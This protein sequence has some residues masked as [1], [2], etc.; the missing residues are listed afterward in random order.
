MKC[1]KLISGIVAIMLVAVLAFGSTAAAFGAQTDNGADLALASQNV[2][3]LTATTDSSASSRADSLDDINEA[4]SVIKVILG[5]FSSS[6]KLTWDSFKTGVSR[7]FYMSVDKLIDSLVVGL[8]KVFPLMSRPDEADYKFTNSNVGSKSFNDK[9]ADGA[10]WNVGYSS[11]TLLTG[12]ELDGN[13][14][15]GGS[16]S[17]PNP[18][19]PTEIL[20]DLRVRVFAMSDGTGNG[21]VVYAV[22][23]AYGLA[24]KDVREIRSRIAGFIKNKN[25]VSVN[26]STLHQHSAID[27]LGLNGDLNKVLFENTFKNA[28]G[29]DPSTLHNGQNKEYM[30]HLYK[31][32][33]DSIIAA[34]NNMEPG[35]MYFSQTDVHEYI[36]DKRDPQTFDPNLNRLCF[37]P[38]NRESKPTWIVNAAIHCVGLGAGTTNIS[39]DYPYFI[40]KQVNAAGANYVQIQGAE[41]AITS[42]TAPVAVEGNTRYQNVEAYGNKL[43][44][45]LVAADKGSRV[46]PILNIAHRDVFV[47][48]DNHALEFIASTG[49]LANEAVKAKDG[50]MRIPTEIGYMEIGTNLAFALI[51]GELAPEIAFGGGTEAKDS[52]TGEDWEYPSM[53]DIVGSR[54]LMVL[55]LTND[56]IGYIIADNNYHSILTENEEL[57]TVSKHEGSRIL[58]E[59]KS[60][61]E[62]VR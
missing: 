34:V 55:G 50:S 60:L 56:Q 41:L 54:K 15:V 26:I 6:D 45:I 9:A 5:A 13:H 10:R 19:H 4:I 3:E 23:D 25:I 61:Y 17:Y 27:T 62:S 31:T 21:I 36:R 59:F 53:Q 7:L 49:L 20:D 1:K 38:D 43:G 18:K 12:N 8:S 51:P 32:T 29:M 28:V 40:E 16:L 22:L 11:A 35:E 37:V 14:Y 44:E 30:E 42:Q 57:L 39:G 58:L 46:E 24:A 52:W 48:V 2:S 47:T 33:A